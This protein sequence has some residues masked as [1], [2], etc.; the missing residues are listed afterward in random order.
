MER[1]GLPGDAYLCILTGFAGEKKVI[2]SFQRC[3]TPFRCFSCRDVSADKVYQQLH[4]SVCSS[5]CRFWSAILC[6]EF[7]SQLNM[8]L[9][10]QLQGNVLKILK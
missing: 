3:N 4:L 6:S 5:F 8:F 7:V 9:Q 2:S 10:L 1:L